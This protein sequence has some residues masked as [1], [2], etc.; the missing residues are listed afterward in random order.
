ML[1]KDLQTVR[2]E[3]GIDLTAPI[4]DSELTEIDRLR[5]LPIDCATTDFDSAQIL[6]IARYLAKVYYQAITL[7]AKQHMPL[8]V[9][10]Y[11]GFY[12]NKNA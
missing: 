10:L 1:L 9:L 8:T 3:L 5:A 11:E 6:T 7:A 2:K 4:T 12:D